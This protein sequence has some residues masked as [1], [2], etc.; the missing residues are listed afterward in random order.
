MQLYESYWVISLT[1]QQSQR[2]IVFSLRGGELL[3]LIFLFTYQIWGCILLLLYLEYSIKQQ[4]VKH[5]GLEYLCLNTKG[6][7][8]CQQ[9]QSWLQ[10]QPSLYALPWLVAIQVDQKQWLYFFKPM[11]SKQNWARLNRLARY[12]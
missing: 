12:S 2:L 5:A 11:L 3:C 8:Y 7:L 6:Q 9:S 10:G 4:R 1:L